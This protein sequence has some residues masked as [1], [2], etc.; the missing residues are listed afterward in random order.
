MKNYLNK[1]SIFTAI[2]LVA[3][4]F[5]GIVNR[6]TEPRIAVLIYHHVLPDAQNRYF[7][8]NPFVVSLENFTE[9]MQYLYDNNFN[10]LSLD[11][12]EAILFEGAEIPPRSVMIQFDDGYYSN[13]VYAYPVLQSFGFTAQLFFVTHFIEELGYNQ[14]PMD[15]DDITWTAAKSIV[16]T[17]DVFETASHS[18]DMHAKYRDTDR[19]VLYMSSFNDIVSDTLRSFDFLNDH[20]AYAYPHGQFND[21][22]IAALQEAGITMAF[23]T[24]EGHVNHRSDPMQLER[25]TIFQDTQMPRFRRIVG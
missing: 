18:H 12:L 10:V 13:I 16:G 25:F 6:P 11:Q 9:Q 21:T 17:E 2:V 24:N 19:T 8:D 4:L 15:H 7:T 1:K 5:I 23:T 20:R 14:L 3:A 22:V